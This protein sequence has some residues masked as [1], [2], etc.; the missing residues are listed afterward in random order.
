MTPRK[1]KAGSPGSRLLSKAE[2]L[3]RLDDAAW[4]KMD[5]AVLCQALDSA[6]SKER[7]QLYYRLN[8]V[9]IV[10][11]VREIVREELA[12]HKGAL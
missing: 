8:S 6:S 5:V 1:G 4:L 10:K 11:R 7:E 2:E 9:G 3:L 12:T